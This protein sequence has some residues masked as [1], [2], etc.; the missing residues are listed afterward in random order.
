MVFAWPGCQTTLPSQS[1]SLLGILLLSVAYGAD[2]R[3]SLALTYLFGMSVIAAWLEETWIS[4]D[5]TA[6]MEIELSFS[7]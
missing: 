5:S 7:D 1:R 4:T 2:P 6:W 3:I